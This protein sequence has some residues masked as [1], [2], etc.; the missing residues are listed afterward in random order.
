MARDL[1]G[2]GT[3]FVRLGCHCVR[4]TLEK[5]ASRHNATVGGWQVPRRT[6]GW[7]LASRSPNQDILVVIHDY[8]YYGCGNVSGWTTAGCLPS[9]RRI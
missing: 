7:T 5:V 9:V 3:N 1:Q 2:A 6:Q 4:F 8:V